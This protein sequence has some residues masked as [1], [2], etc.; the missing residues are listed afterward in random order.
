MAGGT[1]DL[2]LHAEQP[3]ESAMPLPLMQRLKIEEELH[4]MDIQK[5]RS[6]QVARQ[7]KIECKEAN[8]ARRK[9][10]KTS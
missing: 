1:H 9:E 8:R 4:A 3:D 6:E 2:L 7:L 10:E 5:L